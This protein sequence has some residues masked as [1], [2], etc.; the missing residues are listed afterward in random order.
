[1]TSL[2][3]KNP[4]SSS[5]LD[6]FPPGSSVLKEQ[7]PEGDC[8]ARETLRITKAPSRKGGN[9]G[10]GQG[11]CGWSGSVYPLDLSLL[12]QRVQMSNSRSYVWTNP[13][14]SSMR[15]PIVMQ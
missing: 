12:R 10:R 9:Y 7:I 13:P 2:S 8:K 5:P 6:S 15:H 1:M 14:A 11:M 4:S 3:A